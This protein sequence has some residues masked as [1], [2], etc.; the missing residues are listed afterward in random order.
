MPDDS[1]LTAG[2]IGIASNDLSRFT[3]FSIA[4][5]CLVRPE[6]T[7]ISWMKGM[8][9]AANF[10]RVVESME[11]DWL[12]IMGDDHNF[13][14]LLLVQLLSH[15]LDVVVP[16]CLKKFA[17]FE[18]VVYGSETEGDDGVTYYQVADLP[19][20][21]VVEVHAAGTA[22][23]LIRK[24]VLDELP[25]PVFETSKG[26]QNEDLVLCQKI[27][28]AGFR[29]HCDVDARLGHIGLVNVFPMWQ[30]ER[31]GTALELGNGWVTPLFPINTN[32]GGRE[33]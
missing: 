31:W 4:L 13:D 21:G 20:S 29:I 30:G 8:D 16:F 14:P 33:T 26:M 18:P 6:G 22:G 32:T 24:H 11:G 17:P 12:W 1:G 5:L 9:V 19:R 10:N 23:M 15:N 25:R 7:A 2:T 28:D 27:R 3:D